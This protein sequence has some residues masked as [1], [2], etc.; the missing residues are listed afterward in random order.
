MLFFFLSGK[1]H[2]GVTVSLLTIFL[3]AHPN[4]NI[5][6]PVHQQQLTHSSFLRCSS[7]RLFCSVFRSDFVV[8]TLFKLTW[9][10]ELSS[11]NNPDNCD[12]RVLVI[13]LVIF[14]PPK[15]AARSDLFGLS[16][17]FEIIP[18]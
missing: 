9:L 13:T 18:L 16:E 14:T 10:N 1:K 12:C 5:T 3:F 4:E 11:L 2:N 17:L 8:L 15:I 7:C 6:F